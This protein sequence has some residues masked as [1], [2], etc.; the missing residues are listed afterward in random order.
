M[1]G[2]ANDPGRRLRQPRTI[3]FMLVDVLSQ[4]NV[5]LGRPPLTLIL[6][7]LY[8]SSDDEIPSGR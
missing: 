1:S 8:V 6:L 5:I 7:Y 4:Y 3:T 2:A